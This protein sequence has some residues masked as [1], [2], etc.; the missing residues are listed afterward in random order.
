MSID[1][2]GQILIIDEAHNIEASCRDAAGLSLTQTELRT[3]LFHSDLNEQLQ[4]L[5]PELV[6]SCAV[7]YNLFNNMINFML[8]KK[9]VCEKEYIQE[10]NTADALKKWGV[11]ARGWPVLKADF[12]IIAMAD[13]ENK[14]P[15][16]QDRFPP[17]TLVVLTEKL[18]QIFDNMMMEDGRHI[19]DF[20]IIYTAPPEKDDCIR[21][22]CLNPG[23]LFSQLSAAT[24]CVIL[25]SGT[26]SPMPQLSLELNCRFDNCISAGHV[27]DPSQ[28]QAYRISE[29]PSG[30]PLTSTYDALKRAGEQ[31]YVGIAEVLEQLLPAIPGGALLFVQ[32]KSIRTGLVATWRRSGSFARLDKIKRIFVEAPKAYE[33]YIDAL[34][35]EGGGLLVAVCRGSLSEGMDFTD[36]QARA[37]FAFGIP[38]PN[39]FD[40]DVCL[41]REYNDA[42]YR[43]PAGRDWYE[44][45]AYRSL[46]QAVGRCIRHARDY[47]AVF[48][49][50]ER[51][52]NEIGRFPGW[53]RKSIST[54]TNVGRI[55]EILVRFF[56]EMEAKFPVAQ[57]VSLA[58]AFSLTCAKCTR[59]VCTEV[60]INPFATDYGSSAAFLKAANAKIGQFVLIVKED[61]RKEIMAQEAAKVW[62]EEES[63]CY[64]QI[65][66]QCETVVGLK[67]HA[68]SKKDVAA[69]EVVKFFI[70]EL[71]AS[72]A[73]HSCPLAQ[74]VQ[75]PKLLAMTGSQGGQRRLAF[76]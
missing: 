60:T 50:D 8:E 61:E 11:T 52:A 45:Q 7:M 46:F 40:A 59:T 71:Y 25:S 67:I 30:F 49:I 29:S 9:E 64:R 22:I 53:L 4:R 55:R 12:E 2:A 17:E 42:R 41:K 63:I 51:F 57:I 14:N 16:Q 1:L 69:L 5:Y 33:H 54:E 37:V 13:N 21:I 31:T 74:I 3:G 44:A 34:K 48:L 58:A 28:V 39:L 73:G 10:P 23:I 15:E 56:G 43:S 38:F 6:N 19:N 20:K 26:L 35:N 72:Q 24:H 70:D 62:C 75:K 18:R 36:S 76:A 65:V 27:V 32:S 47:G 68:A 66:C